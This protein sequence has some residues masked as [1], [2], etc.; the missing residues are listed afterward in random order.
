MK[1]LTDLQDA[2][3]VSVPVFIGELGTGADNAF[4][5]LDRQVA[6]YD[7][8]GFAWTVWSY[9][10]WHPTNWAVVYPDPTGRGDHPLCGLSGMACPL[11]KS[12]TA[13][14]AAQGFLSS[15]DSAA[16]EPRWMVNPGFRSLFARFGTPSTAP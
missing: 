12:G 3:G 10:F 13:F 8:A 14:D 2:W 6:R 9:K 5:I 1:R 16:P 15:L 7:S 11:Y 4:D